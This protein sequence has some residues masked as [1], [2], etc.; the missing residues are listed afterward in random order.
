MTVPIV[1]P[2]RILLLLLLLLPQLLLPLLS[3]LPLLPLPPLLPLLP[4]LL[5]LL[6]SPPT[7]PYSLSSY[8]PS[9]EAIRGG[10]EDRRATL[11]GGGR[12]GEGGTEGALRGM[13]CGMLCGVGG[14]E[15]DSSP[16][17][18][19]VSFVSWSW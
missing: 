12:C 4:L 3:L 15:E 19:N 14:E 9:D 1:E 18:S 2:P 6:L 11:L 5:P 10:A 17:S 16:S 7:P 13:L 8:S